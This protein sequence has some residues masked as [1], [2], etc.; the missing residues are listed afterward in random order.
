MVIEVEQKAM[1]TS[2]L[3]SVH[4]DDAD[5]DGDSDEARPPIQ[6][7]DIPNFNAFELRQRLDFRDISLSNPE[8]VPMRIRKVVWHD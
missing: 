2:G 4:D 7:H 8:L 5:G 1:P 6:V 3:M